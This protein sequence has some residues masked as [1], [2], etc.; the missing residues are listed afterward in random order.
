M[1]EIKKM[2]GKK[3]SKVG[4]P[5]R[6]GK[7][8]KREVVKK[9]MTKRAKDDMTKEMKFDPEDMKDLTSFNRKNEFGRM[10]TPPK[11]TASHL[12]RKILPL[13]VAEFDSH[14]RSEAGISQLR[15][16]RVKSTPTQPFELHSSFP[17]LPDLD[18]LLDFLPTLDESGGSDFAHWIIH[19]LTSLASNILRSKPSP[20]DIPKWDVV[21]GELKDP[22][23]WYQF[24]MALIVYKRYEYVKFCFFSAWSGE[25][26]SSYSDMID[27]NIKR[28][29]DLIR[30]W[31]TK[32]KEE[33]DVENEVSSLEKE[34]LVMKES[35]EK[36]KGLTR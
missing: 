18:V 5:G 19:N 17:S 25:D 32:G 36:V 15:K 31:R 13:V 14:L 2:G 34:I 12:K 35:K 28:N 27:V 11:G 6:V 16:L 3:R 26:V 29:E 20:P 7:G 33:D 1:K 9:E 8:K 4:D 23:H 24:I 22:T 21:S 30:W 10:M